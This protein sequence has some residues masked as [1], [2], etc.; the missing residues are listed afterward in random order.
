MTASRR[1]WLVGSLIVMALAGGLAVEVVRTAPVRGAV[2]AFTEL[3]AAANRQDVAAAR[4]L[5]SARYLR[6]HD[7][8]PAVEGGLVGLPR[9]IHPNFR[10]WRRG[11]A[12]WL[13]PTNRVGPVFQFVVEGHSWRFDGP[14]GLLRGPGRFVPMTEAEAADAGP[15]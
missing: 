14:V 2:R 5:C 10:A 8:A 9:N 1:A 6:T 7:P 12:V 3:I 15:G 13:C 4:R 11:D